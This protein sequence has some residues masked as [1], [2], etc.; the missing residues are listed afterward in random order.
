MAHVVKCDIC[1]DTC[2]CEEGISIELVKLSS[3]YTRGAL[4]HSVDVC[5]KCARKI[6]EVLKL[7]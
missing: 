3:S 6:K 2:K 5:P 7:C 4:E 1:G